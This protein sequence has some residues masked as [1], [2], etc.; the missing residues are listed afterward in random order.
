MPEAQEPPPPRTVKPAQPPGLPRHALPVAG[1]GVEQSLGPRL[2]H[3]TSSLVP[4]AIIIGFL[5][6]AREVLVPVAVAILLS[7]ILAKPCGYIERRRLPRTLAVIVVVAITSVV[8]AG[9]A[10]LVTSQFY[11]L[12]KS[13]PRYHVVIEEKLQTLKVSPEGTLGKLKTMLAQTGGELE[14]TATNSASHAAN[15]PATLTS[16]IPVEVRPVHQGTYE[17]LW[18]FAAPALK[19]LGTA[20]ITLVVLVFMLHSRE[21]LS[22][23]LI[24]LAGTE[25]MDLT[26]DAMDEAADRVSRYLTMQLI[27]NCCFGALVG[28]G[29]FFIGVP[30][31]WLW[32]VIALFLRFIPYVGPWI[33]AFPPLLLALAVASGWG[34]AIETFSLFAAIELITSNAIEPWLYGSSTGVSPVALLL[35]AIFWTW[36]WGPVGLLLSTPLTV[37]LAVVG[38]HLPNARFL[39]VMLGDE[40]VLSP[41]IRL[42][43]RL[44][45]LDRRGAEAILDTFLAEKSFVESCEQLLLPTLAYAKEDSSLGRLSSDKEKFIFELISELGQELADEQEDGLDKERIA[46][47]SSLP[48]TARVAII[49]AKGMAD[50]IAGVMFKRAF[51]QR[52]IQAKSWPFSAKFIDVLD[53]QSLHLIDTVC[54]SVV[55][56][57]ALRRARY[58]CKKIRLLHPEVKIVIGFWSG[59]NK[60]P[61]A[62][63]AL[64]SCKADQIATTFEEATTAILPKT[65]D[66]DP[67][68]S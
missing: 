24:R 63:A 58:L 50:E 48:E 22:N 56:P 10:S 46:V 40:P 23:R 53:S 28:M 12:A 2:V 33:A 55:P 65:K 68:T 38:L 9:I 57:S 64:S 25:R 8:I 66:E 6:F 35:A 67:H 47:V 49:P 39:H 42:Y 26:T 32:G 52:S 16:P 14:P 21:D 37:C 7:F 30:S 43:Q 61:S 27:V 51:D 11:G 31:P 15:Q 19:P 41:E 17:L 59:L 45:A 44:R 54:I 62:Q 3:T 36:L 13:L 4:A 5:F 18:A 60:L 34:K 1:D 20:F 29:L